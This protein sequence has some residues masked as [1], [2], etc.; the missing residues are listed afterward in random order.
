MKPMIFCDFDGTIT[1][2]DNII[3][4][5]K[6]FAPPEWAGLKDQVLDR[7]ISVKEGVGKMFSL[8]PSSKRDDIIRYILSKAEIREGFA[9]FAAYTEEQGIDLYIVSGGIDF[10]VYP[11][12]EGII[13]KERIYCNLADFQGE[14]IC[15]KWPNPC[16]KESGCELECGCCKPSIIRSLAA[17]DDEVIVIGD[18]VTDLEA[19]KMADFVIARDYL[20]EKASEQNLP[21]KP[22]ETFYDVISILESR[23]VMNG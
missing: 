22:F 4:I 16:D 1:N 8:L 10:F 21:Y 17:S 6:R 11:L 2:S 23:R 12:L 15:I 3:E 7:S 14:R 18:S 19:A 13:E 5:M 9:E 20:L